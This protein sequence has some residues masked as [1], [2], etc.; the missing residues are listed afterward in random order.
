MRPPRSHG[1]RPIAASP[2][3]RTL[4]D[5]GGAKAD[6]AWR[7]KVLTLFPEAFPG[8]LGLSLTGRALAQGLWALETLDIRDFAHDKHRSVDDAPAGGGP[9][10]VL[11]A[12]VVAAAIDRSLQGED[13]TTWPVIC[14][15]A[16]GRPATQRRIEALAAGEG[17]TFLC[18]RFEGIDQRVLDARGVE[19][20]SVGDV[21]LTGGEIPCMALIDAA[22][23][24]RP[25]VLGK[26]ASAEEESYTTGLLEHPQYTRPPEWE[27]RAIPEVLLS[28]H[29]ARIAE[30]RLAQAEA[31]TKERRPDLWRDHLRRMEHPEGGAEHSGAPE[32][33]GE[34]R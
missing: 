14:L 16:R 33:T 6:P 24:L 21:V 7:A 30:W 34:N 9:G 10:M 22:L 11:R 18:G 19:E 26:A 25:G 5:E 2:R 8:P 13:R 28:G 12:D 27:G 31:T 3:P 4:M 17:A 15:A 20:L 32:K 29:H 1:T 23:R